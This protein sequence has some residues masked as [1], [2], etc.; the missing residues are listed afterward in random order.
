MKYLALYGSFHQDDQDTR[1]EHLE[2][3]IGQYR[4]ALRR[5]I[6][7]LRGE[8]AARPAAAAAAAAGTA[9]RHRSAETS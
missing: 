8:R 3:R 9:G 2:R 5:C 6:R 4:R 7:R 1:A